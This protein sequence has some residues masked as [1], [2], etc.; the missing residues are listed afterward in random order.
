MSHLAIL[1]KLTR[2]ACI[3]EVST[4]RLVADVCVALA[5]NGLRLSSSEAC[6]GTVGRFRRTINPTILTEQAL[7]P[8]R[9]CLPE[10]RIAANLTPTRICLRRGAWL[11]ILGPPI[12]SASHLG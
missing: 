4:E 1:L 12:L 5:N 6:G 9:Q 2:P 11:P 3:W 10:S 8:P 7:R